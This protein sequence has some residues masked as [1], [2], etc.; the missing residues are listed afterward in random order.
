[1]S[2]SNADKK[3]KDIQNWI[4]LLF[5]VIGLL[6]LGPP[7][8]T[9]FLTG[10]HNGGVQSPT[11]ELIATAENTDGAWGTKYAFHVY[12]EPSKP[13]FWFDKVEVASFNDAQR[14]KVGEELGL[15]LS[16][17]G[18]DALKISFWKARSGHKLGD[19]FRV[20]GRTISV[21][22]TPGIEK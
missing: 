15:N 21:S 7:I 11:R 20:G 19:S 6:L 9:L 14:Y 3:T 16:W 8:A 17:D 22:V 18:P 2:S 10:S 1:M 4:I 13:H 12:V 5:L